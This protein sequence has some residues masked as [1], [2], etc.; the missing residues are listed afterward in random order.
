MLKNQCI[1]YLFLLILLFSLTQKQKKTQFY[2]ICLNTE[3]TS[4][5]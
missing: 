4:Y 5:V 3:N 1:L 2:E